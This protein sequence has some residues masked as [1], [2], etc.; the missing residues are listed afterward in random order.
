MERLPDAR[1]HENGWPVNTGPLFE[2]SL[3]SFGDYDWREELASLDVPRLVIHGED[4]AFPL[5][6]SREWVRGHAKARL[7]L[8]P[9]ARHLPFVDRPDVF[10]PAVESFLSGKWPQAAR[11]LP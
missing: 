5:E 8:V 11:R 1:E 6:G 7:L 10:F 2:A 3:R 4:E 9:G